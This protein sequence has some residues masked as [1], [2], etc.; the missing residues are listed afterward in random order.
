MN[1]EF[2]VIIMI[3][4]C[5][6]RFLLFEL[7][8]N[9]NINYDFK[10][11]SFTPYQSLYVP[12][13]NLFEDSIELHTR[14][15]RCTCDLFSYFYVLNHLLLILLLLSTS[16]ISLVSNQQF[17]FTGSNNQARSIYYKLLTLFIILPLNF[18]PLHFLSTSN[19][20]HFLEIFYFTFLFFF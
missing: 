2:Y 18:P 5:W 20:C 9:I 4:I 12:D 3:H 15:D 10:K 8:A 13:L 17:F 14:N 16:F 6:A 7:Y 11:K 19:L 1:A